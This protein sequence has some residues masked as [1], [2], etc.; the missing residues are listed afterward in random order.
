M[1]YPKKRAKRKKT[2]GINPAWN[3]CITI[4]IKTGIILKNI[5][6]EK[7]IFNSFFICNK[8]K[9]INNIKDTDKK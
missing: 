7:D 1:V 9:L 4:A 5:I 3:E 8:R 2:F 6:G